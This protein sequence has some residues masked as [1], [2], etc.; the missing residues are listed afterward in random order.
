METGEGRVK[1]IEAGIEEETGGSNQ[2]GAPGVDPQQVVPEGE[3]NQGGTAGIQKIFDLTATLWIIRIQ[4]GWT[5]QDQEGPHRQGAEARW[6]EGVRRESGEMIGGRKGGREGWTREDRA[7]EQGELE[8]GDSQKG[9][10]QEKAI[11]GVMVRGI[12]LVG[13]EET[14]PLLELTAGSQHQE[15]MGSKDAL[16]VHQRQVHLH[17]PKKLLHCHTESTRQE[18]K[19]QDWLQKGDS[20]QEYLVLSCLVLSYYPVVRCYVL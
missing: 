16:V 11:L 20:Y 14:F 4:E 1:M 9:L 6:E 12:P 19:L 17:L 8:R 15:V 3:M 7:V 5:S 13:M 18:R 2:R 10:A